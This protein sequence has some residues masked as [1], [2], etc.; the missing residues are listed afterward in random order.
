MILQRIPSRDSSENGVSSR[1]EACRKRLRL[2]RSNQ[3]GPMGTSE[4]HGD[5]AGCTVKSPEASPGSVVIEMRDMDE[6][7]TR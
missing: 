2:V 6:A 3:K 7:G 4:T 5:F 1:V